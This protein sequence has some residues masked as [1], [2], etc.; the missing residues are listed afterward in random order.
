MA[1]EL[2]LGDKQYSIESD[3]YSY[4]VI[5]YEI[6]KRTNLMCAPCCPALACA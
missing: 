3:V 5:L 1:P 6:L 4:G 2:I